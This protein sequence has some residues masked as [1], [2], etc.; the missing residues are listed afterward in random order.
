M[1]VQRLL[2]AVLSLEK[3][4][5]GK[6]QVDI[7]DESKGYGLKITYNGKEA[8]ISSQY[9]NKRQIKLRLP[10]IRHRSQRSLKCQFIKRAFFCEHK[11]PPS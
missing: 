5:E 11:L 10:Q 2:Q 3:H 6:H 1:Y 8:W 9:I 4:T 7:V